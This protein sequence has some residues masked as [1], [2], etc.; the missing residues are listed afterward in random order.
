M[1]NKILRM[2]TNLEFE[3]IEISNKVVSYEELSNAVGGYIEHVTFNRELAENKI[4][5]WC[6]EEF[7]L[8]GTKP[9][10]V[11]VNDNGSF[12]EWLG[13]NLVFTARRGFDGES[14]GLTDRQIDIIKKVLDVKIIINGNV[15]AR[16][17]KYR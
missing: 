14:Y 12:V 8:K 7:R 10:V 1:A 2:G 9:S 11:I 3:E 6:D 5:V 4:D 17:M 13:G 15:T 16:L